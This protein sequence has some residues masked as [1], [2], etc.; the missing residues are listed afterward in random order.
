MDFSGFCTDQLRIAPCRRGHRRISALGPALGASSGAASGPASG[1]VDLRSLEPGSRALALMAGPVFVQ[2]G[3]REINFT[4]SLI[5]NVNARAG[6]TMW[7]ILN[8]FHH[9]MDLHR[10]LIQMRRRIY[11]PLMSS[12]TDPIVISTGS[13]IGEQEYTS[14]MACFLLERPRT[15][16]N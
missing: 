10:P 3:R 11:W 6:T 15:E 13:A 14:N 4:R 9:I 1:P 2:L 12:T 16:K 5:S 8:D 7:R